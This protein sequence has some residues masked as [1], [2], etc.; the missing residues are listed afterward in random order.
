MN[1]VLGLVCEVAHKFYKSVQ[2]YAE[3]IY[4]IDVHFSFMWKGVTLRRLV[5]ARKRSFLED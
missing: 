4:V 2:R 3:Y 5:R 1:T